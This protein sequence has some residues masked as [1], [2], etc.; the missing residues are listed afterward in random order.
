[1]LLYLGCIRIDAQT[2]KGELS[3][4]EEIEVVSGK[5]S[6]HT[7]LTVKHN[8]D[9]LTETLAKYEEEFVMGAHFMSGKGGKMTDMR[10]EYKVAS[11]GKTFILECVFKAPADLRTIQKKIRLLSRKPK[12]V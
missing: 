7:A 2:L 1:M 8:M 10:I 4:G 12:K 9:E 5:F 6:G 3:T 11:L